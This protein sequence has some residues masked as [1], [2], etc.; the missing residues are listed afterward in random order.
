MGVGDKETKIER[1]VDSSSAF[2]GM[3][4]GIVYAGLDVAVTPGSVLNIWTWELRATKE[5]E[6]G[7]F[8]FL[9]LIYLT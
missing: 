6:Q 7:T 9:G 8:V 2:S 5:R 4:L 3:R 1:V